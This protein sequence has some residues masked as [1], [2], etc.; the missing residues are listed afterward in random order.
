MSALIN[1]QVISET[2]IGVIGR[3][4]S[5]NRFSGSLKQTANDFHVHEVNLD[6]TKLRL[7]EI[8]C[9]KQLHDIYDSK[10]KSERGEG[11]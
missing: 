1:S 11:K 10:R 3:V 6:G 4:N 9:L 5:C 7:S 8:I 2:D